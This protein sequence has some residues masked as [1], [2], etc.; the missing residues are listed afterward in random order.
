MEPRGL[1]GCVVRMAR[2]RVAD[3]YGSM[4]EA[5]RPPAVTDPHHDL[6]RSIQDRECKK[7]E[8]HASKDLDL[9]AVEPTVRPLGSG[10]G[11]G[12]TFERKK[13]SDDAGTRPRRPGAFRPCARWWVIPF[14]NESRRV[15]LNSTATRRANCASAARRVSQSGSARGS[16]ILCLRFRFVSECFD[17]FEIRLV[18]IV[19][20]I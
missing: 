14:V 19:V 11:E 1:C 12:A 5:R 10:A 4:I 8:Q 20:R 17:R 9:D 7:H 6:D 18:L 2:G 13:K 16:L 3:Q 15:Q